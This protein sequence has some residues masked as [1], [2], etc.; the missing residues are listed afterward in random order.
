MASLSHEAAELLLKAFGVECDPYDHCT[1]SVGNGD[2]FYCFDH[3]EICGGELFILKSVLNCE[4]R[5]F[6]EGMSCELCPREEVLAE[7]IAMVEQARGDCVEA[8]MRDVEDNADEWLEALRAALASSATGDDP[9]DFVEPELTPYHPC[10]GCGSPLD[11]VGP[12]AWPYA[13][14]GTCQ[15]TRTCQHGML[16]KDVCEACNT[17]SDF[18]YDAAR[19]R[20]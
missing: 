18:A 2:D 19:E 20:R 3:A 13:Y 12:D 4:T 11:D 17:L 10:A 16:Y 9:L 15:E 7:A 6:L 5:S 14:C 1:W 8:G